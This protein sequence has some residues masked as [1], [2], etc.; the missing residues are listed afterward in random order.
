MITP[1]DARFQVQTSLFDQSPLFSSPS[2]NKPTPVEVVQK[3]DIDRCGNSN[4]TSDVENLKT[5]ENCHPTTIFCDYATFFGKNTKGLT[6]EDENLMVHLFIKGNFFRTIEH[7]KTELSEIEYKVRPCSGQ[8]HK[9]SSDTY[10]C[11]YVNALGITLYIG[12][13][14]EGRTLIQNFKLDFSGSPLSLLIPRSNPLKFVEMLRFMKRLHPNVHP[15]RL[16]NTLEADNSLVPTDE[17]KA[18]LYANNYAGFE[19]RKI[20]DSNDRKGSD[21]K[22]T[23]YFGAKG[24]DKTVCVYNTKV[25][26]GY[27]ATRIEV[28]SKGKHA[29]FLAN[30]LISIYEKAL[31][32]VEER[33]DTV[34]SGKT[35][36]TVKNPQEVIKAI[37]QFQLNYMFAPKTFNFVERS[38]C[39]SWV[40]AGDMIELSWWS[41]FKE[42]MGC[43]PFTYKLASYVPNMQRTNDWVA[44]KVSGALLVYEKAFGKEYS[45]RMIDFYVK[46]RKELEEFCPSLARKTNERVA[47]LKALGIRSCVDMFSEELRKDLIKLGFYSEQIRPSYW[48]TNEI[49]DY[50]HLMAIPT[51]HYP[52]DYG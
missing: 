20:I 49:T 44:N 14:D 25:K 26:H 41:E 11:V 18:A 47:E 3:T 37:Q 38:G 27:D 39:K 17:M 4:T 42:L 24:A 34:S 30:G 52:W 33:P 1:Y 7:Q 2:E 48:K 32:P 43:Q 10:D 16:D 19:N 9:G 31:I 29:R 46:R 28:R 6:K 51:S 5:K 21:G 40:R 12:Y 8:T 15:S 50:R 45:H 36:K 22:P 13:S 35:A 23:L